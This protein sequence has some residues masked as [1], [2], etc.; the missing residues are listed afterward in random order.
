[1]PAYAIQMKMPCVTLAHLETVVHILSAQ[2]ETWG[3]T[4]PVAKSRIAYHCT[5]NLRNAC[6]IPSKP[7]S[8]CL[9]ESRDRHPFA[10]LYMICRIS[11]LFKENVLECSKH[12]KQPNNLNRCRGEVRFGR[13]DEINLRCAESYQM[14]GGKQEKGWKGSP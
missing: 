5:C 1:M 3:T 6:W 9:I 10:T 4:I 8:Q 11:N 2:T 7:L 14:L 13:I 12:Q